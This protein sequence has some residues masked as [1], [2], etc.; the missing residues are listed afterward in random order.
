MR[1]DATLKDMF[2]ETPSAWP[3]LVGCPVQHVEVIDADISTVSGAADKVLLIRD[4]P[5]WIHHVEFQAGPDA[6][7][8]RRMNVYNAVL[9]DR[10]D[11]PVRSSVILLRR[12]ANLDLINGRYERRLPGDVDAYRA[13]RYDV[14]RVWEMPPERLLSGGLGLLPLAPIGN[15]AVAGLPEVLRQ[16]KER[17]AREASP[18][19]RGKLWTATYVLMGLRFPDPTI[20]SLLQEVMG[21]E[22]SVTYQAIIA[23]GRLLGERLG[24]IQEA[25][26]ML[27]RFGTRRF[28]AAPGARVRKALDQIE[29]VDEL[30]RLADRAADVGTWEDLIPQSQKPGRKAKPKS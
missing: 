8:P 27:I 15:V 1:F 3:A 23:K 2:E 30:E 20:N 11:L 19:H 29:D 10:H 22:E 5:L 14:L 26:R 4:K 13:F 16:M 7:L 17:I 28:G 18:S 21:M 6:T 9:E 24:A 12:E 25:R